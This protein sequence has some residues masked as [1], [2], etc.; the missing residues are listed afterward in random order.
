MVAAVGELEHE[1]DPRAQRR[2]VASTDPCSEAEHVGLHI[3]GRVVVECVLAVPDVEDV[4]V[5]VV[6]AVQRV[7]A[8]ASDERRCVAVHVGR[9][10]VVACAAVQGVAVPRAAQCVV[11][12]LP[13]Q[14]VDEGVHATE[15]VG[16]FAA[17]HFERAGVDLGIGPDR[18]VSEL[19]LL[20]LVQPRAL[21]EPVLHRDLVAAVGELEHQVE[22]RAQRRHVAS[23]DSCPEA[24]HVGL[25]IAGRVVA[26]G[27]LPV[28]D[29]EEVG[30]AVVRTIQRVVASASDERC[31]VAVQVHREHVVAGATVQRVTVPI[32][33]QR[34]VAGFAIQVVVAEPA[35]QVVVAATAVKCIVAVVAKKGV[36]AAAADEG[37]VAGAAT[38]CV[39]CVGPQ[40]QVVAGAC[41]EAAAARPGCVDVV[42]AGAFGLACRDER[43]ALFGEGRSNVHVLFCL[44]HERAQP[45]RAVP[46]DAVELRAEGTPQVQKQRCAF[47]GICR[48]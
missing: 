1:V 26:E 21:C 8:R 30:V 34:V 32:G 15:R 9:E 36:V 31:R 29:V 2:H 24:E 23:T 17:E 20:E 35:V 46:A 4:G 12:A 43:H 41:V 3:A 14:H 39:R 44:Q 28:A 5:A 19:D 33:C 47:V 37:V 25:H 40:Q 16:R 10:H 11:A 27:V 18:A 7:V 13:V 48:L 45:R 22:P 38:Q 42:R 6:R